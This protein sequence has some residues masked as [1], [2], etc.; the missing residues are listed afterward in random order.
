[1]ALVPI[2]TPLENIKSKQRSASARE[3]LMAELIDEIRVPGHSLPFEFRVEL[4][5]E[6]SLVVLKA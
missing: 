6:H 2:D 4:A 1:V 5:R 3:A